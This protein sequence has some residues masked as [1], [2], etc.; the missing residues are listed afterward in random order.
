MSVATLT[1]R[2]ALAGLGA[3]PLTLCRP[4]RAQAPQRLRLGVL[5]DFSGPYSSWGG[6]GSVVATE[7]AVEEFKAAQPGFPFKVEV[8]SADFALKPD[9]AV[10]IAR[11]WIS[12]GIDAILDI[13]HTAS[14]LAVNGLIRGTKA[15]ALITGSA[16]DDLVTK[17]CS[18]NMVQWTYDQYSLGT[19]T[20]AT[21]AKGGRWFFILQDSLPGQAFEAIARR[22]IDSSGGTVIGVVRTPT[23]TPD[24]AGPLVQAQ[25]S[26]AD[27]IVLGEGGNDLVNALKQASEFG[28]REQGQ[29]IGIPFAVLP[30]IQALGLMVTQGLIFTEAFYWDL[31]EGTRQFSSRFAKRFGRPPTS[32]QAGAYSATLHYL[33]AV[34]ASNSTAGPEVVA[35]MKAIPVSDEAFGQARVREDGRMVH[36]MVLVQVKKPGEAKGEWDLYD[37]LRRIPGAEA[38]RPASKVCSLVK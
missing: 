35:R 28:I 38:F 22:A 8:I 11:E 10:T 18:P 5:S 27:A 15:A 29:R 2:A 14:A 23:G 36:D 33:K 26:G 4:A 20:F 13:P 30:D 9:N 37:V 16:G 7:M 24:F 25:T 19:P 17:D 32:L 1:R 31:D 21:V 12:Q 34:A 3:T 6:K